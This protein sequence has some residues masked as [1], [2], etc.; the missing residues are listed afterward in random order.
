[1]TYPPFLANLSEPGAT[2]DNSDHESWVERNGF[3]ILEGPGEGLCSV[4]PQHRSW[5]D[6]FH[7]QWRCLRW[8]CHDRSHRPGSAAD[9]PFTVTMKDLGLE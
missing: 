1:M 3:C 6:H 9:A 8:N 5:F 7:A 2:P 4:H